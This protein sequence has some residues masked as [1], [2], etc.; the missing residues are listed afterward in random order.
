MLVLTRKVGEVIAIGDNIK[1]KVVDVKGAQVRLGLEAP[2]D[3]RIYREEIYVKI[4][5]EN[6]LAAKW[7]MDDLKKLV[8][9]FDKSD[10]EPR[11]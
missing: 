2:P 11:H 5:K 7:D 10:K 4:Q 3:L 8:N 1:I 9:F 6:M